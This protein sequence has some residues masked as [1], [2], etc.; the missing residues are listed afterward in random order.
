LNELVTEHN[1]NSNNNN[2][3]ITNTYN[4]KFLGIMIDNTLFWKGHIDKLVHRLS[5]ACYIIRVVK[6]FLLQDVLKMID[7]AKFH[8][9]MTYRLLFWGNSSYSRDFR[10]QKRIIGIMMGARSRDS[11]REFFFL[12]LGILP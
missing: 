8:L 11:C 2:K 1:N 12:I 10:L 9:V 5:Q 6:L 3:L 7:F 4:L